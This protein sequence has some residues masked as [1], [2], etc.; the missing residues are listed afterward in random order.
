MDLINEIIRFNNEQIEENLNILKKKFKV[1]NKDELMVLFKTKYNIE[2]DDSFRF[3]LE[4]LVKKIYS[5]EITYED[6]FQCLINELK[7]K[8]KFLKLYHLF[9]RALQKLTG[10][11]LK[12]SLDMLELIDIV[13]K[14]QYNDECID[15]CLKEG[16]YACICGWCLNDGLN[17]LCIYNLEGYNKDVL[18]GVVCNE[19]LIQYISLE[20]DEEIKERLDII[21]QKHKIM[22]VKLDK[23][24]CYSCNER[25]VKI[26]KEPATNE[27][28]H[29]KNNYCSECINNITISN[30]YIHDKC[31]QC[32]EKYPYNP[33]HKKCFMCIKGKIKMKYTF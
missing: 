3:R 2:N 18:I 6:A 22:E 28:T 32:N 19:N 30:G 31:E 23:K 1:N 33:N 20:T 9:T 17:N 16:K 12:D 11:N 10:K 21:Y 14:E 15:L 27:Q 4:N 25:I 29:L 26:R 5:Q 7:L 8:K 24:E 13:Q